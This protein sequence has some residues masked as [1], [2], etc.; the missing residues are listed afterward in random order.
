MQGQIVDQLANIRRQ[1]EESWE[2]L[3]ND[4]MD[5]AAMAHV[6]STRCD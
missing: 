3:D 5:Q 1:A 4:A 2:S 6:L